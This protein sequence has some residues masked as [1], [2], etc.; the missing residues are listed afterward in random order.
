MNKVIKSIG[1]IC[2]IMLFSI[3]VAQ[4]S[5]EKA[6]Y[7][8]PG[9]HSCEAPFTIGKDKIAPPDGQDKNYCNPGYHS[10]EAPFTIGKDHINR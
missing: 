4:A 1:M 8:N 5:Q 3:G 10:C 9:Y 2:S 7:C 6:S